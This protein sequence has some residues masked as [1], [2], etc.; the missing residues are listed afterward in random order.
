MLMEA[1]HTLADDEPAGE[2]ETSE[3]EAE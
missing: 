1:A 3:A 2:E